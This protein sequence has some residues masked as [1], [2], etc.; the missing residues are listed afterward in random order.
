M[1][2][3]NNLLVFVGKTVGYRVLKHLLARQY[4]IGYVFVSSKDDKPI[5]KLLNQAD[6]PWGIFD[7][8][9]VHKVCENKFGW[10]VNAW[11]PH[12][13]DKRILNCAKKRL[14][15]HPSLVPHCRGNDNAAWTLRKGCP[16]GVSLIEMEEGIDLGPI[17]YQETVHYQFPETG[18]SLHENLMEKAALVFEKNWDE[19]YQTDRDPIP[20]KAGGSA[21]KRADTEID[22][23]KDAKEEI[24]IENFV[25]WA[26]AHDFNPG[27]TAEIR[28]NK[29]RYKIRL[30]LEEIDFEEPKTKGD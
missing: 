8:K 3:L 20:Q 2:N 1:Q 4:D 9:A 15:V 21:F 7:R 29:K 17:Y 16:A 27:T 19:I 14:N 18:R 24:S 11:S 12:I 22:R 13:L 10:I 5:I 26:M 23:I 6:T 28:M 25:N 30:S